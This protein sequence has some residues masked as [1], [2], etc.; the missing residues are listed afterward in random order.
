MLK[1]FRDGTYGIAGNLFGVNKIKSISSIIK[2]NLCN[3]KII[4][5]PFQSTTKKD[6]H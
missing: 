2:S 3:P 1:I 4:F 6:N 5:R